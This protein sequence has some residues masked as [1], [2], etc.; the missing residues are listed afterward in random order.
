MPKRAFPPPSPAANRAPA[1]M[2]AQPPSHSASAPAGIGFVPIVAFI[3]A[4]ENMSSAPALFAVARSF[5]AT[6]ADAA[7]IITAYALAYGVAQLFWG[8]LAVRFG[9]RAILKIGLVAAAVCDFASMFAPSLD[10]LIAMRALAGASVGAV[11]PCV[12]GLVGDVVP[13]QYRQRSMTNLITGHAAGT[14]LGTLF[15]G[16]AT[17]LVSWHAVF[18][19]GA[20]LV[21]AGALIGSRLP[22]GHRDASAGVF[23]VARR[24]PLVFRRRWSRIV[25]LFGMT[26]GAILFAFVHFLAPALIVAGIPGRWAGAIVAAYGISVLIW[27]RIANLLTRRLRIAPMMAIG[28]VLMVAGLAAAAIDIGPAG[29]LA[30]SMLLSGATACLHSGLQV[31]STEGAPELRGLVVPVFACALFTGNAV[32]LQIIAQAETAADFAAAYAWAAVAAAVFGGIVLFARRAYEAE[33]GKG[34]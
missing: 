20:V 1:L 29:I 24:L 4:F 7:W 17:D 31:W 25:V 10:A 8:T 14:A 27:S 12:I 34:E 18:G 13:F 9:K 28:I 30:A 2:P 6:L 33:A 22:A 11:I 32:M 26:E 23:A 15:G 5:G 3:G 19:M 16:V 21:A